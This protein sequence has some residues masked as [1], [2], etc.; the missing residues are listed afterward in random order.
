MSP[1]EVRHWC[2]NEGAVD[3]TNKTSIHTP[4]DMLAPDADI[5]LAILHHK[6]T[7]KIASECIH[8]LSHQDT[9]EQ[10]TKEEREQDKK[11]KQCE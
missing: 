7:T 6:Q 11:D 5:I 8:V 3:A 10:K 9:K 2:D 4:G 1:D